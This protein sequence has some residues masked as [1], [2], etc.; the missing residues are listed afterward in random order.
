MLLELQDSR[1]VASRGDEGH[2]GVETLLMIECASWQDKDL[3]G[4]ILSCSFCFSIYLFPHQGNLILNFIIS[5]IY[6][7]I[8]RRE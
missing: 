1:K 8:C 3:C 7:A 6:L 4:G 2:R 5:F